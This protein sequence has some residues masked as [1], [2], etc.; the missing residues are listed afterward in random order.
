MV[1]KILVNPNLRSYIRQSVVHTNR[2]VISSSTRSYQYRCL[3]QLNGSSGSHCASSF[4]SDQKLKEINKQGKQNENVLLHGEVL[5]LAADLREFRVGDR[6]DIPYEITVS[7]S[8]QDFWQ[9]V[10]FLCCMCVCVC[11][12]VCVSWLTS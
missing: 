12:C 4:Q 1:S 3:S 9:S 10:G 8:I 2:K 7:E 5:D 6:L 11:V